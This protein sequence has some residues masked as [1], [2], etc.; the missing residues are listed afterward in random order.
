MDAGSRIAAS[1]RRG[2]THERNPTPAPA[3]GTCHQGT[4]VV[5]SRFAEPAIVLQSM[6]ARCRLAVMVAF[7]FAASCGTR[8][9]ESSAATESAAPS[10]PPAPP[11]TGNPLVGTRIDLSELRWLVPVEGHDFTAHRLTLLRWWTVQCPFCADSLPA[12]AALGEQFG[13]RGLGLVG[14]F[15]PKQTRPPTDSAVTAAARALGFG[16]AIARDDRWLALESV[17]RRGEL[18]AATSIS[19]LVDATGVV[20]WVHAGPRLH[21]DAD[22]VR[23]DADRSFRE[24]EQLL[25]ATLR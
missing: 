13:P 8:P 7:A 15:H 6:S 16:G 21:P 4:A 23:A 20:R 1:T 9:A 25:A 10:A 17:R 24:L 2:T 12:L 11:V 14:V 3:P 19:V 18:T 22:P 5:P